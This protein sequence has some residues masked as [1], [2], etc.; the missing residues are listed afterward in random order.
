[1]NSHEVY[2]S[3]IVDKN[4]SEARQEVE[5][6]MKEIGFG[7]LTEIDMQAKLAEKLGAKIKPYTILGVCNP[8][9]A[10][11]AMQLEEN[12]GVFLPCKVVLKQVDEAKTEVLVLNPLAPMQILQNA[13]LDDLAKDVTRLLEKAI[14]KYTETV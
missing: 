3:K 13:K 5:S 14:A 11:E 6:A 4:F 2:F 12:I 10:Y 9:F 8:K 1:M 7:I